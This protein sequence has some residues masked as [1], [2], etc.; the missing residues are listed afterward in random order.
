MA[1]PVFSD[2]YEILVGLLVE[3]RRRARVSQRALAARLG[4]SQSHVNMIENRQRRVELREFYLMCKALGADPVEVFQRFT[5][6]VEM[7][8]AA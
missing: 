8:Q 2:D 7:Q 1:N 5:S 6:A 3:T 4:K